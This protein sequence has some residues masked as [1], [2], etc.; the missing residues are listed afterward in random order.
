MQDHK[1][2]IGSIVIRCYEFERMLAFWQAALHY[3]PK[4]P[5]TEDWVILHDPTGSGPNL[6]LDK[7]PQKRTGKRSWLHLDLYAADQTHEVKRLVAL[8][9]TR[10][11]WRYP[12]DADY[13]VLEDPDGNL[14]CVIQNVVESA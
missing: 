6:S 11:P 2:K 5:P 7:A 13:V 8:G 3:T 10:Y 12:P 14:F 1:L 9:A 4:Y